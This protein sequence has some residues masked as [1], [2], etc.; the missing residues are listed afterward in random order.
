M[1]HQYFNMDGFSGIFKYYVIAF[2]VVGTVDLYAC[3]FVHFPYQL[4]IA[5]RKLT[6]PS[7]LATFDKNHNSAIKITMVFVKQVILQN[8]RF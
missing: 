1:T 5:T 6:L 8:K 7:L 2:T 4:L 3:R